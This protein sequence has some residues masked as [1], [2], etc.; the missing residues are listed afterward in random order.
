MLLSILAYKAFVHTNT[1]QGANEKQIYGMNTLS[2]ANDGF[3][4]TAICLVVCVVE[5][6][7]MQ[8][9]RNSFLCHP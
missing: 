8:Q 3:L 1:T 2:D 9:R 6:W 7:C 4:Y 5:S